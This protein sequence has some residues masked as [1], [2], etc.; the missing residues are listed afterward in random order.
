MIEITKVLFLK[1]LQSIHRL[2][3]IYKSTDMAKNTSAFTCVHI[4]LIYKFDK[5]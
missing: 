5:W 2:H 1:P 4:Q 3:F